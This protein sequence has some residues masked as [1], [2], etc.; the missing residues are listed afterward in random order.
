[1][2]QR[3]PTSEIPTKPKTPHYRSQLCKDESH[4]KY[5][6]CIII[7]GCAIS[8]YAEATPLTEQNQLEIE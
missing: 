8:N 7:D 6:P 4:N 1:M 3:S 5:T 2:L